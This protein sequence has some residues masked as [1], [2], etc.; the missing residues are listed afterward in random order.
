MIRAAFCFYWGPPLV[1]HLLAG[2][3]LWYQSMAEAWSEYLLVP[4]LWL[5]GEQWK[6][7]RELLPLFT[8]YSLFLFSLCSFIL[9]TQ[10]C[11]DLSINICWGLLIPN[12][13]GLHRT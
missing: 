9:P 5:T 2:P 8:F 10:Y 6:C 11:G 1:S 7:W 3:V 13:R 4:G 12:L